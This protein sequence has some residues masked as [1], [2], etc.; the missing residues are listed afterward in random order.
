[1]RDL[2]TDFLTDAS[3]MNRDNLQ[4]ENTEYIPI[5]YGRVH[6]RSKSRNTRATVRRPKIG[7][8][9]R[10]QNILGAPIDLALR[11]L[12]LL[13]RPHSTVLFDPTKPNF[14][15]P[16]LTRIP[17]IRHTPALQMP[18]L[19]TSDDIHRQLSILLQRPLPM[20]RH[21]IR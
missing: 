20:R 18:F 16:I 21:R 9:K 6:E 4:G 1:M 13:N 17:R 10:V 2:C 3:A 15:P 8:W 14:P 7:F 5:S 19:D 11:V 12:L